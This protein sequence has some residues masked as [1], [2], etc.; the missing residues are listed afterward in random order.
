MKLAN[1]ILLVWLAVLGTTGFLLLTATGCKKT[2]APKP[3]Q[4]TLSP[5][6]AK[7]QRLAWNLKTLV[8]AYEKAGHTSPKWD[9][10]VKR[11]MTEFARVRSL[12]TESNE[13]WG[14]IIATN[15]ESAVQ[16]GCDDPMLK[17]L[18]IR[19]ALDQTNSKEA[20][21]KAFCQTAKDMQKSTYPPVRKFYAATWALD[22]ILYTYG[23]NTANQPIWGEFT[24]LIGQNGWLAVFVP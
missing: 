14:L 17:Y 12:C 22:Q 8:E 13:A 9:A 11:A 20:F 23:T 2:T 3:I 16:A 1:S 6:Q 10:P 18:F 4:P 5:E 24:P 15:C 19:F 21:L 7:E